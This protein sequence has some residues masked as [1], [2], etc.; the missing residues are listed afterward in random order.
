MDYYN[1][2][3]SKFVGNNQVFDDLLFIKYKNKLFKN[4]E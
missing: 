3:K 1:S 4:Y 2:F